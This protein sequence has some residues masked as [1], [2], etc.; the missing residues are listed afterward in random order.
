M[1][2]KKSEA[3]Q[4]ILKGQPKELITHCHDQSLSLSTK[5]ANK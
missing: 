1:M 2:G 4:Q 3:A 5:D